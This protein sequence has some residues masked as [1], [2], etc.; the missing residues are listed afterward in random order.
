MVLKDAVSLKEPL[1]IGEVKL[2]VDNTIKVS[3]SSTN[4]G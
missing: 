2:K 4:I 1:C 3:S